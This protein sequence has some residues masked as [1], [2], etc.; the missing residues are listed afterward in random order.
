V[1]PD[2]NQRRE[3]TPRAVIAGIRRHW[4]LI[5]VGSALLV[6]GA[7]WSIASPVGSSPD[8]DFHLGSIWCSGPAPDDGCGRATE[9]VADGNRSVA[10]PAEIGPGA[11]CFAFDATASAACQDQIPIGERAASRAND[12]LYP[13]GFYFLMG[14]FVGDQPVRSALVMRGVSWTI[15]CTLIVGAAMVAARPVR[16]V[17]VLAV[18]AT[19][20]PLALFLFAS[21]NP[22]GVA[23]AAVG[24]FWAA[25]F[26]FLEADERPRQVAAAT[27]G[28][29]AAVLGVVSRADAGLY[30]AAAAACAV[31]TTRSWRRERVS[32]AAAI[33]AVAVFGLAVLASAGQTSSAASGASGADVS[34]PWLTATW[35][36]LVHLPSLWSGSLGT[37]GLG[38]LDTRMPDV[39]SVSAM[40]V[41]GGLVAVGLR[42]TNRLKLLSIGIAVAPIVVVPLYVLAANDS[43]VG[44]YVQ[45][46]YLLP[47][48]PVIVAV[49][50]LPVSNRRL[51]LSPAQGV[52]MCLLLVVAHTV[53]L[54]AN[55]RRYVTG[56]D[57]LDP[58]LGRDVEWW[59]DIPL[60]P[61]SIWLLGSVAFAVVVVLAMIG[62][63]PAVEVAS[64]DA[65][66]IGSPSPP[67]RETQLNRVRDA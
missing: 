17:Y 56:Q 51:L 47:M 44:W 38:W 26:A 1:S 45:P 19:S 36:N 18:L 30:L 49:V 12:G 32:R 3:S 24:A 29:T 60:G 2:V 23:V 4:L 9:E 61:M 63:R 35:Y 7:C 54:H 5:A 40:L 8:D 34:R 50:L 64:T 6:L 25:S 66:P 52:W 43:L 67:D 27:V 31:V 48:L 57:V 28:A 15:A 41:V 65:E 62:T 59:W 42:S 10:V 11:T 21:N 55:L 20:V 37:W 53:A 16:R 14:F 33:G 22:S 58:H 46:R 39:V 13:G